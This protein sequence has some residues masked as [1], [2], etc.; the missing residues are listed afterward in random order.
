MTDFQAYSN[1]THPI[2]RLEDDWNNLLA[3]ALDKGNAHILRQN[4]SVYEAINGA[5]GKIDY[6]DT[7][8]LT[9]FQGAL[10][11]GG[12]IKVA[13]GDFSFD[14]DLEINDPTAFIGAGDCFYDAD[15]MPYTR[16]NFTD[17]SKGIRVY[18][19]DV[20][21]GQM[22]I[23]NNSG[24][25]YAAGSKGIYLA[26][27]EPNILSNLHLFRLQIRVFDYGLEI[28]D[29]QKSYFEQVFGAGNN[30]GL[31]MAGPHDSEDLFNACS[32]SSNLQYGVYSSATQMGSGIKFNRC[33]FESNVTSAVK[34][35]SAYNMTFDDACHYEHNGDALTWVFDLD[36]VDN[37]R[38]GGY[39]AAN[40][41]NGIRR[42]ANSN[43]VRITAR[44]IDG[45]PS[46]TATTGADTNF[47]W[48]S[49]QHQELTKTA[50]S[51]PNNTWTKLSWTSTGTPQGSLFDAGT[52][53][54]ITIP[55]QGIYSVS[56]GVTFNDDATGARGM[57]VYKNNSAAVMGGKVQP[58]S[59]KT[60]IFA[61]QTLNLAKNDYLE[62]YVF[63][64]SGDALDCTAYLGTPYFIVTK[65]A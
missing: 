30:I 36:D 44:F 23:R 18:S 34:L 64:D 27:T 39:F 9:A 20:S 24:N 29:V 33:T 59:E 52:P 4:G 37:I 60:S 57:Y 53:T 47:Y 25:P 50:T 46:P 58:T 7:D 15:N 49:R 17:A 45:F 2:V 13:A 14:D 10:D 62:V 40:Q 6:E 32:F 43:L 51:I 3:H 1:A 21:I 26:G 63:Q 16:I 65:V 61:H 31:Y 42:T 28:A 8:P 41:T 5:T 22:I 19:K 35:D 56:A 11:D 12:V 54:Q 48:D 38:I 55:L